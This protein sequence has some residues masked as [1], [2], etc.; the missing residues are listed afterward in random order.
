M[1]PRHGRDQAARLPAQALVACLREPDPRRPPAMLAAWTPAP[2]PAAF[3]ALARANRVGPG[4]HV[5]L[6]PVPGLPAVVRAGLRADYH[7]QVFRSMQIASDLAVLAETLAGVSWAVVKGPATAYTAFPRPDMRSYGDLDVLVDRRQLPDVVG[8]LE[9]A[10]ATVP[11]QNWSLVRAEQRA[12]FLVLLPHG[13]LLDLHWHLLNRGA[14]RRRFRLDVGPLLERVRQVDLDATPAPVLDP[15]DALL[16]LAVHAAMA[17]GDRLSWLWDLH[18]SRRNTAVDDDALVLR[19]RRAGLHLVTAVML[20]KTRALLDTPVAPELLDA[21]AGRVGWRGALHVVDR[22]RPPTASTGH[23]LT[24]RTLLRATRSNAGSSLRSLGGSLYREVARPVLRDPEHP[25]RRRGRPAA[26]GRE[27]DPL[28]LDVGGP[29][30]RARYLHEVVTSGY[31]EAPSPRPPAAVPLVLMR[32][33]PHDGNLNPYLRLLIEALRD[34]GQ[35]VAP[36]RWRSALAAGPAV[37]HV[38]WPESNLA[39]RSTG[40]AAWRSAKLLVVLALARLRGHA[41]VWTAHN[42]LSHERRHPLLEAAFWRVFARLPDATLSLSQAGLREVYAA[43]PSLRRR[44]GFVT[45]HGHY[46]DAYPPSSPRAQAR[47]RLGLPAGG[48]LLLFTGQVRPYKNVVHLVA[49]FRAAGLPD[50]VRLLVAGP[51]PDAALRD[52]VV[53]AAADDP[54]V[55]LRLEPLTEAE[56]ADTL[57][58]ADLVVLPFA[59]VFNSGSAMLALSCHRPVLLP[60][61]PAFAELQ[62]EVGPEWVRTYP[63]LLSGAVLAEGLGWASDGDRP[64]RCGLDGFGW[65]AVAAATTQAYAEVARR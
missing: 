28:Y 35:P 53:R 18:L 60:A 38:H 5:Q 54:A 11:V 40:R 36:L 48:R 57:A 27:P 29:A 47:A 51:C 19:A 22:L 34:H 9:R 45:R 39:H 10:G 41:V 23:S 58:A 8:R 55:A 12:E 17:G 4:L 16:H 44:P 50:D 13:T 24:G 31:G 15:T 26:V 14:I 3:L 7:E 64:G 65:D 52:A 33:F 30:E 43:L 6:R 56:V 21:L 62:A 59:D 42:L 49:T 1:S 61:S 20:E 25:W 32:P 2:D 46:R 37:V 63:G